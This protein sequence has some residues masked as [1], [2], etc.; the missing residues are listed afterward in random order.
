[1]RET[2]KNTNLFNLNTQSDNQLKDTNFMGN[3]QLLGSYLSHLEQEINSKEAELK[4]RQAEEQKNKSSQ[5]VLNELLHQIEYVDYKEKAGT[6]KISRRQQIVISIDV[7]LE[8]AINNNWG[9]CTKNGFTYVFNSKYWQAIEE[10]DFKTFLGWAAIKMGVPELDAKHYQLKDE[11]YRQFISSSNLPTPEP[12]EQTLINLQ[13]GT[14]EIT[15]TGIQRLR[16]H[17]R[18]D[19]IKYQLPFAYD[20]QAQ[21]PLFLKFLNRVLPDTDC[22]M[23]LAEYLGYIFTIGLKLEKVA[24]LYGSGANGKSVFF[25][26]ANALLG[27]ENVSNYSLQNL[28][29]PDAYQRAMLAN[30][31][32]NYTSELNGKLEAAIFKQLASGEPVE[33][34]KIYG[35]PFIMT[36]YAKLMFNCNEL[37]KDIEF[38]NAFFRRFLIIPF[39]QTIPEEEQDPELSKKI[40]ESE[41]SGI[42]NWVLDGLQRILKQK[43]FTQSETITE[44]NKNYRKEADSVALFVE[45]EGYKPSEGFPN[46]LLKVLYSEYKSF[47][48]DNGYRACSCKTVSERLRNAGFI[49][50][51]NRDGKV[52]FAKK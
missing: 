22:Q 24:I 40:I 32:L 6:E 31:L 45:E 46:I 51:K 38:T 50:E 33:V 16:E 14:F 34:R 4:E 49:I 47:C 35:D 36:N 26:I 13:N 1:M 48:S 9:L 21:C 39:T 29:K 18:E 12:K 44:Q 8:T 41:L 27:K 11:L 42:F 10:S 52:V 3:T 23:V 37:P 15:S 30:I 2:N 19:F 28:T 20:P 7:I 5:R 25:E 17:R 43:K